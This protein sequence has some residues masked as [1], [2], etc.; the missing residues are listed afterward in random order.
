ML[1]AIAAIVAACWAGE[2][3]RTYTRTPLRIGPGEITTISTR[4]LV[5]GR[6]KLYLERKEPTASV[7]EDIHCALQLRVLRDGSAVSDETLSRLP[8]A[9]ASGSRREYIISWLDI[10]KAGKYA[11]QV[12]NQAGRASQAALP[13]TSP[14]TAFLCVSLSPATYLTRTSIALTVIIVSLM[15]I[16]F[17]LATGLATRGLEN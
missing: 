11:F 8:L 7:A 4:I 17:I 6:Y 5:G 13:D 1:F 16:G 2:S 15:G 14:G 9:G 12:R 10:D 3:W